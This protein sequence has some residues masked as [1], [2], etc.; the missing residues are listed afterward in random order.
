MERFHD[1][2][3]VA[4]YDVLLNGT[5]VQTAIGT[6]F[7]F[8]GLSCGTGYTLG[9]RARDGASNVSAVSSISVGTT[10]CAVTQPP[11]GPTPPSAPGSWNLTFNDEFD[12]ARSE[13]MEHKLWWNGDTGWP[14]EPI[15]MIYRGQNNIVS[16]G[17]V[18]LRAERA[19]PPITNWNGHTQNSQGQEFSWWSG[20][21]STG[22][23]KGVMAPGFAQKYG[24]FE[25]RVK[26]AQRSRRLEGLL[27]VASHGQWDQLELF[28]RI[29]DRHL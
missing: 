14:T 7:A 2:V 19:T 20:N 6:S 9:V 10:A 12:V 29:R 1:N 15:V 26:M 24:Y 3:G 17:T 25:A 8:S 5:N 28:G 11:G 18:A 16:N 21:I 4:G 22:G 23:I 27:D 13:H